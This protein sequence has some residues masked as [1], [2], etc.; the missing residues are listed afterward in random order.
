MTNFTYDLEARN[1]EYLGAFVSEITGR[2][3]EEILGFLSEIEND[4]DLKAHVARLVASDPEWRMKA[5]LEARYGRRLGWYAAVR[6]LKPRVVVETGVDKGLGAV[7]L[8]AA[9]LRNGEEGFPGRYFGTDIN[10]KA[11][12]LFREPYSATGTLLYGDSCDSL[13]GLEEAIDLFV[14]DSDHSTAYEAKEYETI[15]SKLSSKAL[16]LGD[17]AHCNDALFQFARRSGRH[18]LFFKECPKDHWYPGAGIGAAF[19]R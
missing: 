11:G 14:N 9:L 3:L 18:F 17:N 19:R 8:A 6:A 16:I 10:P 12:Y 15:Q 1:V 4:Q 5:D 2:P 7:V 13:R